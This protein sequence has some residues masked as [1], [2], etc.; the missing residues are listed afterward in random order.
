MTSIENGSLVGVKKD[1]EYEFN[2][3]DEKL[4]MIN[5]N[6]IILHL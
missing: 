4:Y 5:Q 2:I 6:R 1:S 3:F